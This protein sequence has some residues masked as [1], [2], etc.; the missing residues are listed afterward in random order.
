MTTSNN[1]DDNNNDNGEEKVAAT[2]TTA[3]TEEGEGTTSAAAV[4]AVVKET[5]ASEDAS[6]GG[7]EG[8]DAGDVPVEEATPTT[9]EEKENKGG[10][11]DKTSD[12]PREEEPVDAGAVE[13]VAERLRFFFSDPNVR[14]DYFIRKFL[15]SKYGEYPHQLPVESLL[16]FNTIKQ[17]TSDPRVVVAAAGTLKDA[18]RVSDDGRAIGRVVP[19]TPDRMDDNIPLTLLVHNLP[20]EEGRDDRYA[21]SAQQIRELFEQY[22]PITIVKLRFR[23]EGDEPDDDVRPRYSFRDRKRPRH[24]HQQQHSRRQPS[25]AP[26]R[27]VAVGSALVEFENRESLVKAAADVVAPESPVETAAAPAEE[28]DK[29]EGKEK[30][31]SKSAETTTTTTQTGPKRKLLL[32]DRELKAVT[33][34]QYLS[35][36]GCGVGDDNDDDDQEK[37]GKRK[38]PG[39]S[40]KKD[41][42]GGGRGGGSDSQQQLFK[43]DWKKGCVIRVIRRQ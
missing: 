7:A 37:E 27:K 35:S 11:G 36:I 5:A 20:L 8:A 28:E 2:A 42:N 23:R 10:D 14:Q 3:T 13:A 21:A 22:G 39:G 34:E 26:F 31:D 29:E 30:V 40:G 24:Q 25:N 12:A 38:S 43:F 4:P 19:F 33:L 32:G 15:M 41:E 9:A 17:H 18:L 16:K 1:A 6:S